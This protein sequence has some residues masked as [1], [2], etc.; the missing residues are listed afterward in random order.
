LLFSS[1][2]HEGLQLQIAGYSIET[3]VDQAC[4]VMRTKY[5]GQDLDIRRGESVVRVT[6][7]A[8]RTIQVIANLLDNAIK[9]SS[10]GSRVHVRWMA[11]RHDVEVTVRDHGPGINE[12]DNARLFTRFGTLGHQPRPGQVGTGIG[13]YVSKKMIEA[14]NGRIWLTSRP[15]Y[16]STFHFTLPRA[17]E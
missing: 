8:Q 12:A 7:D 2:E 16:G 5:R 9:Y 1:V 3:L 11:H 17:H 14:M 4:E 13:L 10:I 6:A 15:G